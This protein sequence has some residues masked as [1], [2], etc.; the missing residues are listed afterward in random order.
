VVYLLFFNKHCK[1]IILACLDVSHTSFFIVNIHGLEPQ[2]LL[3]PCIR[4]LLG[5]SLLQISKF[6][7]ISNQAVTNPKISSYSL[8]SSSSFSSTISSKC[9]VAHLS[10]LLTLE[11][12]RN[13]SSRKL[14]IAVS[15]LSFLSYTSPNITFILSNCC[16]IAGNM[17]ESFSLVGDDLSLEDIVEIWNLMLVVTKYILT[18]SLIFLH[19][20]RC[21]SLM[22]H[23]NYGFS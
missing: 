14:A 2:F 20:I 1:L 18:H 15:C 9:G 4:N 19:L 8:A 11:P 3:P 17:N 23:L 5:L 6:C 21:N 13:D 16:C 7:F 12:R 22:F 10:G